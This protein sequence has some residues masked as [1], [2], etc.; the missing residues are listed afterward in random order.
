M[1]YEAWQDLEQ[2]F[3]SSVYNYYN[4]LSNQYGLF[5]DYEECIRLSKIYLNLAQAAQE[6]DYNC[7]LSLWEIENKAWDN[8][9]VYH[10]FIAQ[11][12]KY[13]SVEA[14]I[15][16]GL[17]MPEIYRETSSRTNIKTKEDID[18]L[19]IFIDDT[20]NKNL[21]IDQLIYG[22]YVA[23]RPDTLIVVPDR[24]PN[25]LQLFQDNP[26]NLLVLTPRQFEEFIAY[27]YETLGCDVELTKATRDAGADVLAWHGGPL[28][29]N[30]LTAIQ[31]K[32][33]AQ[34]RSV[35]LKHIYELYGAIA[36]YRA[37]LGQVVTTSKFTK[38]A[39]RFAKKENIDLV[40]L[41]KLYSELIKI[42]PTK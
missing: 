20:W 25:L 2:H 40:D 27:L 33:Y 18:K 11:S 32:R 37:D 13:P 34:H 24:R 14:I 6:K 17:E 31:V 28:G 42:S 41:K 12:K 4:L 23:W 3:R 26:D 38:E 15:T 21:T 22:L 10:R 1:K 16:T 9:D 39:K 19:R 8:P 5:S 36:H 29:N 7:F 35:G 30:I